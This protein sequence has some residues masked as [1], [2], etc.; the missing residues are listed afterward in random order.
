MPTEYRMINATFRSLVWLQAMLD[1]EGQAGWTAH[2]HG[3]FYL[4][5]GRD[6]ERPQEHRVARVLFHSSD[7]AQR[8]AELQAQEGWFLT[9]LG[10]GFVY[11]AREKDAAG[12]A[13][14]RYRTRTIA[15]M[16]PGG[17]RAL[18]EREGRDGWTVRGLTAGAA[19]F[20][21]P[22]AGADPVEHALDATLLRTA[23]TTQQL[24]DERAREGWRLTCA[25][26]LFLAFAR[27]AVD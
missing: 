16:T 15:L 7:W 27:P 25:S 13:P 9:A 8:L 10:P 18:L 11:F 23:G 24:L 14:V 20:S 17:I 4:F 22:T 19:M 26:R 1:E 2:A 6:G 21:K 12:P 5:L 3:A